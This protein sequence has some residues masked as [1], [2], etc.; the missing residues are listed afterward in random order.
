MLALFLCA[1]IGVVFFYLCRHSEKGQGYLTALQTLPKTVLFPL[2]CIFV[3]VTLPAAR[4]ALRQWL[5]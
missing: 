3:F 5:A 4:K 2:A 1:W